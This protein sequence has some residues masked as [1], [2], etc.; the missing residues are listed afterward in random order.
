MGEGYLFF[1]MNTVFDNESLQKDGR[2]N[3]SAQNIPGE[4]SGSGKRSD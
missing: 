2:Y 3:Q 4:D 1:V